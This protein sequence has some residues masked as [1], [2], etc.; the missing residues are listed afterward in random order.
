MAKYKVLIK[1][2]MVIGKFE[3]VNGI[4]DV[5]SPT[6]DE[7]KRIERA[8]ETGVLQAPSK[9]TSPKPASKE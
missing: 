4:L 3:S 7:T 6:K 5:V 8:V 9:P 1:N 2:P